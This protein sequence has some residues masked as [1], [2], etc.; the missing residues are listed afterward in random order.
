MTR[1]LNDTLI[2]AKVVE[3]G[4]F[5][6]RR[7]LRLPNDGEPQIRTSRRGSVR[8]SASHDAQAR[9]HRSRQCLLRTLATHRARLDDA[10]GHQSL[11]GVRGWLRVTAPYSFAISR[12]APLFGEFRSRYPEVRVE[13]VLTNEQLD[14]IGKE[15]DLA[16]P[17]ATARPSLVAQRNVF[18]AR[19]TQAEY[20]ARHGE[21]VTRR[22]RAPP[23]SD[24]TSSHMARTTSGR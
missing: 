14:L 19:S 11:Q 24:S 1:D 21:P 8:S 16:L 6:P 22:P 18:A 7:A 23:C 4:G 2:F 15:I 13:M 5:I 3:H 20:L 12:I 10:G 9:S 17:S